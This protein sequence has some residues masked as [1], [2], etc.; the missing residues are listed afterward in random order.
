MIVTGGSRST[1]RKTCHSD[2]SS[3]TNIIWIDLASNSGFFDED[4]ES[5][6][7][8]LSLEMITME[9]TLI[10]GVKMCN[11]STVSFPG[12]EYAF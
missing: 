6:H 12:R 1:R 11:K 5:D 4:L 9:M 2:T 10:R 7:R 8:V 3:I